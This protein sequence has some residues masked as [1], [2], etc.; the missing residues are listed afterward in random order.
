M[1]INLQC[2]SRISARRRT[3]YPP[4]SPAC[5]DRPQCKASRRH[6]RQS[7]LHRTCKSILPRA[8]TEATI[9]LADERRTHPQD[10]R[11][12]QTGGAGGQHACCFTLAADRV[13][14]PA[15][16]LSLRPLVEGL[17]SLFYGFGLSTC[18]CLHLSADRA[19][20]RS[21]ILMRTASASR[22][23][24]FF[25]IVRPPVMVP[26]ES[27]QPKETQRRGKRAPHTKRHK[28]AHQWLARKRVTMGTIGGQS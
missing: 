18:T 4:S 13:P 21:R 22:P 26:S 8:M 10:Y 14:C 24:S 6:R 28:F 3:S 23:I 2:V 16:V 12:K 19:M 15:T 7:R 25:V 17:R 1:D 11:R 9:G 27:S 5:R 20:I